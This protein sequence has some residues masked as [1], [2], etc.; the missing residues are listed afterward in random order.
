[1]SSEIGLLK[2][3]IY[4]QFSTI[5]SIKQDLFGGKENKDSHTFTTPDGCY[6]IKFGFNMND[7]YDDTVNAGID[8]VKTYLSTLAKDENSE[9]LIEA[10][11]KLLAKDQKGHLKASMVN[12]LQQMEKKSNNKEFV[13]AVRIIR[14]A[15]KPTRSKQ[16]VK[17]WERDSKNEWK[18]IPLD[19]TSV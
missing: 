12:Q 1:M 8:K 16:Y 17:V 7:D 11:L 5:I 6:R 18:S 3:F 2:K 10:V 13:D 15:Y 4:D 14:D 9:M 19:I